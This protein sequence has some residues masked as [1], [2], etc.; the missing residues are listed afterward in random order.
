MLSFRHQREK[1]SASFGAA[2]FHGFG[3]SH[4]QFKLSATV[5]CRSSS[6]S[7]A[8]LC[9]RVKGQW[10]EKFGKI[11]RGWAGECKCVGLPKGIPMFK[12]WGFYCDNWW[13]SN[14]E[15]RWMMQSVEVVLEKIVYW[16]KVRSHLSTEEYRSVFRADVGAESDETLSFSVLRVDIV[17]E[18]GADVECFSCFC[19]IWEV[20]K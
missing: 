3:L 13:E 17:G 7:Q 19:Y 14:E 2:I 4:C 12:V 18:V 10:G 5:S 8:Q 11:S 20:E 15:Y 9:E 16:W 6:Q 1:E